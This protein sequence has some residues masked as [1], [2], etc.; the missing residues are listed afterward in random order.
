MLRHLSESARL[1]FQHSSFLDFQYSNTLDAIILRTGQKKTKLDDS[2]LNPIAFLPL[3]AG[4]D[5]QIRG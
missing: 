4:H 3:K 1:C 2:G 5:P